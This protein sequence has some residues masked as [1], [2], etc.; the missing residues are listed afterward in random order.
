MTRGS[1]RG[2]RKEFFSS[3][4]IFRLAVVPTQPPSACIPRPF[5]RGGGGGERLREDDE[6]GPSSAK[7]RMSGFLPLFL[8]Y[9]FVKCDRKALPFY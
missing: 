3:S 7:L 9:T 6:C 2:R 1:T 5:L 8:L 4:K